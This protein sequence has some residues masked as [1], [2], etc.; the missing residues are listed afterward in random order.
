MQSLLHNRE[1]RGC[2]QSIWPRSM[3]AFGSVCCQDTAEMAH[4]WSS[5]S[6]STLPSD[7]QAWEL[8]VAWLIQLVG[9]P[10]RNCLPT[11]TTTTVFDVGLGFTRWLNQQQ[12]NQLPRRRVAP[13]AKPLGLSRYD[14]ST[15]A[16]SQPPTL[17]CGIA[18]APG[19]RLFTTR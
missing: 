2:E 6:R 13:S 15:Y 5:L 19:I 11:F 9:G 18:S 1:S 10:R 17:S 16:P 7:C 4:R 14:I 12:D 8:S 3:G